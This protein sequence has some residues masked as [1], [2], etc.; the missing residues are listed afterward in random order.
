MYLMADIRSGQLQA[1]EDP[2]AV[3]TWT[4]DG[5]SVIRP[6]YKRLPNI[7]VLREELS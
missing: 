2:M 5:L 7:P 6:D 4:G 1:D 3:G